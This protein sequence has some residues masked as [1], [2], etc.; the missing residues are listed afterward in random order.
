M[1]GED[2]TVTISA[3]NML[4]SC[5]ATVS[6]SV[7]ELT[8]FEAALDE[9]TGSI[10]LDWTCK[11][12]PAENKWRITY[13]LDGVDS[14]EPVSVETDTASYV[15]PS[16]TLI[17]NASYTVTLALVSGEKLEGY[18]STLGFSTQEAEKHSLSVY[19]GLFLCP[20]KEDWTIQNLGAARTEFSTSEKIA[21]V[22][23]ATSDIPS[24]DGSVSILA[25]IHDADG[26]VVDL[27]ES[28]AVWK[29][30]WTNKKCTGSFPRTPQTP[31]KYTL[32]IY[33]NRKLSTTVDFTVK[34]S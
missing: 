15:F 31:G 1:S 17:P 34:A 18:P 33:F 27:E 20:D 2:Y 22:L 4:Q 8:S 24:N 11:V 16:D 21:C 19:P 6:P 12:D 14:A 23:E 9:E 13:Q 29:D 30:M 5:T 32:S 10:R 26:K 25:V 28:S 3:P 7:T